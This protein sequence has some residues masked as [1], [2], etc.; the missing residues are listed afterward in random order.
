MFK[1]LQ[2]QWAQ[3]TEKKITADQML[4]NVQAWT[5][6]DLQDKGISVESAN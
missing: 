2:E 5:V 4:D 3:F 6:K 1:Q